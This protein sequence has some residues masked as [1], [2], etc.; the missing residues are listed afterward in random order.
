MNT[1]DIIRTFS[2]KMLRVYVLFVSI[3]L[4]GCGAGGDGPNPSQAIAADGT[5]SSNLLKRYCSVS[6]TETSFLLDQSGQTYS[7]E[8]K[9]NFLLTGRG[10][11]TSKI[12]FR[13]P[14]GTFANAEAEDSQTQRLSGCEKQGLTTEVVALADFSVFSDENL[15]GNP[16][17]R[18][19]IEQKL[20]N[21]SIA[22][23]SSKLIQL[24]PEGR[25]LCGSLEVGFVGG[26]WLDRLALKPG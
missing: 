8:P 11:Q 15:A 21:L 1:I 17:C 25:D 16:S 14:D 4:V 18:Y 6:F 12:V 2:E 19:Q 9:R 3:S 24:T 7:F 5:N 23:I 20:P 22:K 13:T 10:F 26:M